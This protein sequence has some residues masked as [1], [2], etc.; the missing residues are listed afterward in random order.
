MAQD[1]I[2]SSTSTKSN[3]QLEALLNETQKLSKVGG[4][5]WDV[6]RQVMTWTNETFRIHGLPPSKARN[7]S[8]DL[9]ALSV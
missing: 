9:I 7:V 1:G 5:E 6:T 4:W 8:A 2:V 3:L